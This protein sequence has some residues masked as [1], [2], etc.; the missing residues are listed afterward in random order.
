MKER[1]VRDLDV[2]R[3]SLREEREKEGREGEKKKE[4]TKSRGESERAPHFL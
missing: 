3:S 4:E 2:S 1:K